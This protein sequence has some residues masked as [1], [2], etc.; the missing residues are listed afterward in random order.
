MSVKKAVVVL[1]GD[2]NVTGTIFFEQKVNSGCPVCCTFVLKLF[3]SQD[4]GPVNVTGSV[5]GLSAGQHG[6]HGNAL[7][8]SFV[9]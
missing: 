5:N 2:A 7:S 1:K 3:F 6:F 4:N 8:Q 9:S